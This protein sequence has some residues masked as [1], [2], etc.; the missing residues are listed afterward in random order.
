[1]KVKLKT[2]GNLDYANIQSNGVYLCTYSPGGSY[3]GWVM[4]GVKYLAL[5]GIW[6]GKNSSIF[7]DSTCDYKKFQFKQIKTELVEV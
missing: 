3:D 4:I 1:M 6:A 7:C 5:F 2:E